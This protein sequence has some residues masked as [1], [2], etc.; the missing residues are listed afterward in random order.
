MRFVRVQLMHP[1]NSTNTVTAWKKSH[2]I[3]PDRLD[4]RMINNL[5]IA[6]HAYP[7]SNY[8]DIAF[9]RWNIAAEI[10][11]LIYKFQ[12][13]VEMVTSCLKHVNSITLTACSWLWSRYLAWVGVFTRKAWSAL[14]SCRNF[15]GISSVSCLLKHGL[16]WFG[17]FV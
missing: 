3:L 17:F 2:F 10:S 11:E 6:V 1:Y 16:V 14:F 8:I 15:C 12:R 7:M 4:F 13:L 5:L 9:G